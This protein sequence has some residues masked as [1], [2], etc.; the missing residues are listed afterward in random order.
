MGHRV[1]V[2]VSTFWRGV[3]VTQSISIEENRFIRRMRAERSC[4]QPGGRQVLAH[5]VSRGSGPPNNVFSP[6]GATLSLRDSQTSR[7]TAPNVS[8]LRGLAADLLISPRL[9]PWAMAC[10]PPG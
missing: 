4:F 9:T 7:E 1:Q 5:G 10:R 3:C 8:P 2:V 6:E